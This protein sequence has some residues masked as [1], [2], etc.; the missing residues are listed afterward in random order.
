MAYC[1]PR[2]IPLSTF[3]GWP[4]DDQDSALL[5]QAHENSRCSGCGTYAHEWDPG[6]GGSLNAY[7]AH[8]TLCL[9]CAKTGAASDSDAVKASGHGVRVSLRRNHPEP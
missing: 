2:G 8:T 7:E 3:L 9:G 6:Q 5:W 1:G 4:Q